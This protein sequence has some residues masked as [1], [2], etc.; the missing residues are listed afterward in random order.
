MRSLERN[1]RKIEKENPNLSTITCFN[2]TILKRGFSKETIKKYFNLLV[3]NN[4]YEKEDKRALLKDI[5]KKTS[6]QKK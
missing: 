2:K 1:F 4:D 6:L 3:D 5:Y